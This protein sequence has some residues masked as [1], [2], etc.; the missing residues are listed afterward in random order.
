MQFH[1]SLHEMFISRESDRGKKHIILKSYFC[2][3]TLDHMIH[4]N[5]K[6]PFML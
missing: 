5:L 6:P 3:L 1:K 4:L 2:P